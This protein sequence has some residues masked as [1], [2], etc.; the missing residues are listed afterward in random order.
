MPGTNAKMNEFQALMG[1]LVLGNIDDIIEKGRQIENLYR[2]GLADLPGIRFPSVLPVT[3][4]HN[5]SYVPI[6][7]DEDEFGLTRDGLYDELKRYNVFSRR[8]FYP[9]VS[10]FAC[11]RNV[12][13]SDPLVTAKRV[14]DS[15]LC[16]P[17]YY[18]LQLD[19]VGRILEII[20]AIARGERFSK[21]IK[22]AS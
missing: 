2:E 1:S 10:D 5:Y 22:R 16:L 14:A 15:I 20:G 19:E 18:N 13:I 17:T 12:H 9:L 3:I 4:K 21:R 7:V 11:Y 6:E 8:Y